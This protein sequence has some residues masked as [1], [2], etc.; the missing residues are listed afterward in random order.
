[1]QQDGG[2]QNRKNAGQHSDTQSQGNT[3]D[4]K[5]TKGSQ[6]DKEQQVAPSIEDLGQSWRQKSGGSGEVQPQGEA[7]GGQGQCWEVLHLKTK[8][9]ATI[10]HSL[11]GAKHRLHSFAVRTSLRS[12]Q[13]LLLGILLLTALRAQAQAPELPTELPPEQAE[14]ESTVEVE[15]A[16]HELESSA[17]SVQVVQVEEDQRRPDD[18][19]ALLARERG[20][21]LRRFGGLG[22]PSRISVDGLSGAQVPI[23]VDGI[24]AEFSAFSSDPSAIPTGLVRQLEIYRGVVPARFGADALGA[25]VNLELSGEQGTLPT[26]NASYQLGSFDTHRASLQSHIPIGRNFYTK[27]YGFFD[28]ARN[29]YLIQVEMGQDDGSIVPRRVHRPN[30]NYLAF[31]GGLTFGLARQPWADALSVTAFYSQSKRHIPHNIVMTVPYGRPFVDQQQPGFRLKYKKKWKQLTLHVDG[32]GTFRKLLFVDSDKCVYDWLGQCILKKAVAGEILNRPIDQTLRQPGGL[33][34]IRLDYQW[35][36][37]HFELVTTGTH[38]S[39]RGNNRLA[40]QQER[41]P[42]KAKHQLLRWISGLQHRW[43]GVRFGFQNIAFLKSYNQ[44]L[45]S[46]PPALGPQ[47]FPQIKAQQSTIGLGDSLRFW[48]HE[49]VLIKAAYEWTTRLASVDEIF[50]D[51]SRHVANLELLPER[52]HNLNLE[53]HWSRSLAIGDLSLDSTL[54]FRDLSQAIAQIPS[55]RTVSSQNVVRARA[56]SADLGLNWVADTQWITLAANASWVDFRNRA[57]SGPFLNFKG[58]R[59]PALPWF[60]ANAELG[61]HWH[62]PFSERDNLSFHVL[63]RYVHPFY[64]GWES[65]GSTAFK[66]KVPKQFML[67]L[68]LTYETFLQHRAISVAL[69]VYNILDTQVFDYVGAALPSRSLQSK[70]S[71]SL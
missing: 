49:S 67:D 33:A 66:Q 1:M 6:S 56:Y 12:V 18:L 16:G 58:D 25:A 2:K 9:I 10:V 22:S 40:S 47:T 34:R 42:A 41:D 21:A 4:P 45:R 11:S 7:K 3:L 43:E 27:A 15:A 44:W 13:G 38:F 24:P 5:L 59:M 57:N 54:A 50:G 48:V 51:G 63:S 65:A 31:G 55:Q 61:L 32:A 19:G 53:A 29:D 46:T 23:L 70:I 17:Q 60:R 64:R 26:F 71:L 14:F 36:S 20:V 39:R 52:S 68:D 69:G 30:A 62:N 37:H 28:S 8:V 35:R